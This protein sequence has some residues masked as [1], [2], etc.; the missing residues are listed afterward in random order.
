MRMRAAHILGSKTVSKILP[1]SKARTRIHSQLSKLLLDERNLEVLRLLRDDPRIS[2]SELARRVK[3][4]APTVRER[5]LRLEQA[6][7]IMG[8][9]LD[10]D[11][12]ALGYWVLAYVRVKPQPGH[13]PEIIELA[14]R[15]P[16]VVECHRVTGEDCF[17]LKVYFAAMEELDD[18]LD[19]FLAHGQTTTS[20][21]QS[22]P[23]ALRDL[24]LPVRGRP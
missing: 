7:V 20:I 1:R 24:P 23:V 17:V 3:L 19:R 12:V 9:R 11:P 14:R 10:V 5:L 15:I 21:V 8:W 16:Q 22:T 13:L 6:G 18:V 4:S 2:V